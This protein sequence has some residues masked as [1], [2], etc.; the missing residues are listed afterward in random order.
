MTRDI[1]NAANVCLDG[2]SILISLII[3]ISIFCIKRIDDSTK[4][5]AFTNIA[6]IIY[7]ITD[8]VMWV[9]EGTDAAWKLIVLPVSTFLFYFSGVFIFL[10]YIR[11]IIIY[12]SYYEKVNKKWWYFC[13]GMTVLYIIFTIISPFTGFYYTISDDNVYHRGKFFTVLVGMEVILYIEALLLVLKYHK[14]VSNSE[15]IG[16]ASFIFCPFIAQII[17][18][19]NYGI[20]LNNLGLTISFFII[21]INMNLQLKT[22]LNKTEKQ[23]NV[24]DN[25]KTHLL[26]NTIINLA[27]LIE[28]VESGNN[29]TKRITLYSRLI[30]QSCRKN[31]LYTD[32]IDENFIR[33]LH[34]TSALHD[35]GDIV[36]PHQ[37]LRKPSK[38][39]PEEYEQ[40]KTHAETGSQMVN[41]VLAVGF[42]PEFIKMAIDICKYHHEKWDGT[43]YPQKIKGKAIPLSAR[44]VALADV[45]DALV[46]PRCYKNTV[47][48]EEAFHIIDN[49][50]GK[51]FDPELVMEFLKIKNKL[52]EITN[53]Y[54]DSSIED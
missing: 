10:F 3:V 22:K 29:H 15:S 25:K 2:Y 16:F 44:I 23:L 45:Y 30:A 17:Q 36:I 39:T 33:I 26:K 37:I 20:A 54:S 8:L 6:A 35:I 48:F 52:I 50:S 47:S 40:I 43:G 38:V 42:E 32:I 7:G 27:D 49:E 11:Y 19:A 51:R 18:I 53:T 31:G 24:I 28:N 14:K 41:D 12:F 13:L 21:Y 34:K 46:T 4:W 1:L 5:F 9:S